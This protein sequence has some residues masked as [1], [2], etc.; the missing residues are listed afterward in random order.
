MS[1][2]NT[3][4]EARVVEA[5]A[6]EFWNAELPEPDKGHRWTPRQGAFVMASPVRWDDADMHESDRVL[7]RKKTAIALAAHTK[8]LAA[9]GMVIVPEEPTEAMRNAALKAWDNVIV[10]NQR[11][12]MQCA[13]ADAIRAALPTPTLPP[14]GDD[15]P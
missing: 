1:K 8:V 2:T 3:N 12:R 15:T 10:F 13:I 11:E 6:R 9:E 14:A 5:V 4:P 7:Y